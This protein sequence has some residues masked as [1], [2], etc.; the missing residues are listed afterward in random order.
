MA[1]ALATF[2]RWWPMHGLAESGSRLL[3]ALTDL[4]NV[5]L[6]GEVPQFAVLI[7][8]WAN[9][10]AYCC[11]KH[12]KEIVSKSGLKANRPGYRRR[13]EAGPWGSQ[14]VGDARRQLMQPDAMPGIVATEGSF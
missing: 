5:M 13:A 7:L 9:E 8:Y 12:I 14:Q 11:W 3:S 6:R 2:V 4:V 1:S 10:C